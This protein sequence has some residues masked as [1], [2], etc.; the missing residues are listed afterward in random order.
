MRKDHRP[1]YIKKL[2][3]RFQKYYTRHFLRPQLE[4]LG[5]GFFFIKPW[6]VELFGGPISIGDF[7]TVIATADKKIRLSVWSGLEGGGRI[8][9]GSYCLLC[10]GVRISSGREIAI[11]DNCMLANNVYITDADWHDIYN[12]TAIGKSA[13][14]R[15]DT[16]VWI[17]DSAIVCKGVA[18]GKNS[19]IGAGAIV[20]KDIPAN[21]I[22]AGNPARVVKPLDLSEEMTPRA[23]WFSD[24]AKLSSDLD[25]FDKALLKDNSTLH[26]LRNLIYPLKGE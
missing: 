17:G 1:Y 23:Q 13:S 14:V 10:P 16:N 26:W 15:I 25:R 20:A 2:Y 21:V 11:G 4:K 7:A 12:R 5:R 6:H 24:P 8:T 18:I 19:I 22:A 9:I 3:L